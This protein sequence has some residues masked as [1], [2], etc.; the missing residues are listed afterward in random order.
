MSPCLPSESPMTDSTSQPKSA[1]FWH[2][3]VSTLS[4]EGRAL[5]DGKLVE[6]KSG[7]QFDAISPVD[8]RLIA[9]VASCDEADV[10]A[11]VAAARRAFD[12]GRWKSKPPAE[13][14]A[15]LQRFAEL[16]RAHS[17]ELATLVTLEMGKPIS[18]S[19]AGDVNGTARCFGWYAESIDK[20][21]DEIAPTGERDLAMI[22][23]EPLGVVA[24][25]VPW[26][27]P[28]VTAAWKCG[29]ALAMGNSVV[30]KPA[31]QSPLSAIRLG[32]IALEAGIPEG[33]LNVVPGYGHTAG[34]A[35]ACHMDVDGIFFTGST[36]TGRLL[37]EYSAKSNLKKVGLELG[38]KSPNIIL[39]S[40]SDIETAA[41]TAANTMF[42]N[43]GEV[44]IAPSRLI[45][46]RSVLDQ[47]KEVIA[48]R[49]ADWQP[50]DPFDPETR[51]G[52]LVDMKHANRV[53]DYVQRG[54]DEGATLVTGGHRAREETGG[55]YVAPTVFADVTNDMTIASEEIFGPV[56][57]VIAV[58]NAEGAVAV[59]NDSPY[60]LA[61]SVWS[62]DLSEAHLVA[63]SLRA[64]IVYVNCYDACD[65]TTPFGGYKQSGN[66]RDK[67]LHALNEYSELK[68]TWVR[69]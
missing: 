46:E 37:M 47:V 10:D 27:F 63:K 69:L 50:S 42:A 23:R 8:G 4:I 66:G 36:A 12:D 13:R 53:M 7:K 54:A 49:A 29:P 14:K 2:K 19:V 64:G 25:V 16:L 45:V 30:L 26:N 33:V 65:M 67:S 51:M 18:V 40:Y 17:D 57:S 43:Q 61:A 6:A 34:K 68:T 24:A 32:Q 38:G 44:C 22:T 31:E 21:Y 11:A 52:A 35:L 55:A 28:L 58:D 41:S 20:I 62:D 39:S 5:I 1:A 48:A 56:L 3:T 15:I 9:S 60:G 59:A